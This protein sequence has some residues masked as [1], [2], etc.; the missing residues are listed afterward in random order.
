MVAAAKLRRAQDRIIST[1]PYAFKMNE[2]LNHLLSVADT[3]D[4]PIAQ[5]R[6]VKKSLLIAMSSDRGLC[7]SFNTN[8]AKS[9]VNYID[10]TG[11]DTPII[12]IGKKIND[13]LTKRKYNV[14]KSYIN[15]F[16]DLNIQKSDEIVAYVVQ[17]F[18]N[19]EF[20]KVDLIYNEF[21]SIIKQNIIVD[22]FLPFKPSLNDSSVKGSKI[23][24]IYEPEAKQILDEL[25]PKQLKI[26]FWK[27]LLESNASE[28]GARMTAME[29]ATNNAKD[30]LHYLELMYNRARQESITTELL[31]IVSGAEAL[32]EG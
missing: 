25:I 8:I 23:D 10:K 28:Q 13:F 26:H 27:A 20:D 21:K 11:K 14:I 4:Y 6:E 15:F 1:R 17:G 31:E 3:S 19:K 7:G 5:Q 29:T 12:A 18:L 24:Y 22:E 16:G 9:V 30:L 32:K 2:L